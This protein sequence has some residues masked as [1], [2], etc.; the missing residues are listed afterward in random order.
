ME[1][2]VKLFV[3][4]GKLLDDPGRYSKLFGILK[5]LITRLDIAYTVSVESV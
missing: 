4:K 5:Y 1:P 3:D 2:G